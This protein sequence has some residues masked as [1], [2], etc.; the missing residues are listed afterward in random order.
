MIK[1]LKLVLISVTMLLSSCSKEAEEPKPQK[2]AVFIETVCE[3]ESSILCVSEEE[4]R[5]VLKIF[6]DYENGSDLDCW[7]ITVTDINGTVHEGFLR[8]LTP[9][10]DDVPCVQQVN[11]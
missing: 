7:P 9:A 3:Q 8:G 2:F 4:F 11:N 10:R 5:R 1:N 6:T